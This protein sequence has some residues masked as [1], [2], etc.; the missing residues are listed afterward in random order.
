MTLESST[1]SRRPYH[2]PRLQEQRR[3]TR[4]AILEAARSLF[5][6]RGYA[7]TSMGDI[8]A[9]A[10]VSIKTV[11]AAF[12]TKAKLLA[13]L[14]DVSVVGD[15]ESVSLAERTWFQEMLNEPDPRRQLALHARN[16]RRIKHGIG[17]LSEVVRRAAQSDPEIAERWQLIQDQFLGNQRMVAESLVAK[18]A[19]RAELD[20]A[21]AVEIIWTLNHPAVYYLVVFERGWSEEQY[22][23]WLADAFISQLL[24]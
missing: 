12:G 18:G 4:L 13:A 16:A 21:N 10:R 2:S 11:E 9:A 7:G 6:E 15:A 5:I 1:R 24:R 17:A 23:H 22:E 3:Q 19:L 20:T 14:W 8:A